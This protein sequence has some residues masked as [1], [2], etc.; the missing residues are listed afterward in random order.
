MSFRGLNPSAWAAFSMNDKRKGMKI[1]IRSCSS[2]CKERK[3]R[4][5]STSGGEGFIVPGGRPGKIRTGIEKNSL[6]YYLLH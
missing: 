4:K 5:G 2:F 3:G 6:S 1:G